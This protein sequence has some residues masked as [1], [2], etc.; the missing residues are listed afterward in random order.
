MVWWEATTLLR[1]RYR[2]QTP[3]CALVGILK[4][5]PKSRR[6]DLHPDMNSDSNQGGRPL[7]ELERAYKPGRA[8]IP[9]TAQD[10]LLGGLV[11]F[12][13][14]IAHT[15]EP[16]CDELRTLATPLPKKAVGQ[17]NPSK[18]VWFLCCFCLTVLRTRFHPV[19]HLSSS[20][21]AGLDTFQ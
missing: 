3:A 15:R 1:P 17:A 13:A 5:A 4:G 9:L 20:Q 14:R 19:S 2:R 16:N 7:I 6:S 12:L 21:V 18:H 8:D 10:D 11:C